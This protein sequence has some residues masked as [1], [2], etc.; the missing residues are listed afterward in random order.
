MTIS[1]TD[2]SAF[3]RFNRASVELLSSMRFAIALLTIISIASIIGTVIKQSEPYANYVNQ[4]GPFWAEIFNGLGLFAVYTAWW[5]LLILAFLVV[6]VSF[7]VLRNAPKMLADI[8]AWKEHVKEGGLRALHHH[9][10]YTSPLSHQ[11]AA[12][13]I[14]NRLVKDGYSVKTQLADD[15][16]KV[17]AKKGAASKWGY[18]FAHSAIVLICLG[19]LL[20]GD[21]FTRGQIWFGGKSILPSN[22]QGMLIS[23]IPS[24]HKLS[25]SNPSYRANI[26]VPEGGTSATALLSATSGSI[27]QELPFS[28]ELKKFHVEYYSTGMPKLF[29]SEVLIKDLDTGKESEAKIKVNEPLIHRGVAIYQSSFEDGGS[30]LKLRAYPMLGPSHSVKT[31]FMV[32]GEVG[33]ST[34]LKSSNGASYTLEF[35]GFRPTNVENIS[36]ASGQSDARGVATQSADAGLAKAF[37]NR[38]GSGAKTSK[39]TDLKNVGPSV[40][41]KLRDASGQA[42]EY[43]NYMQPLFLDGM[44]MF[45][46]GVRESAAQEFRYLRVPADANLSLNEWLTLRTILQDPRARQRAVERFAQ[47]LSQQKGFASS[48]QAIA[49]LKESAMR[50]IELFAGASDFAVTQA[51]EAGTMPGGFAALGGFIDQAVPEAE[52]EKAA[53]VILKVLNGVIWEL[54]QEARAQLNLAPAKPDQESQKFIQAATSALSDANFYPAPLVFQLDSFEEVK[55]SVFQVTRSPGKNMV[56]LGCLLLV[57]GIFAMFYLPERRIWVR[58]L[59]EGKNLFAMSTSRKTLDF[60]KEFTKYQEDLKNGN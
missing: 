12:D 23:E 8:R 53:E 21:L 14:A 44:P 52:R 49:Q 25:A 45:L 57:L 33:Q 5:F 1:S 56:Y 32:S 54:W 28:I 11:A 42:R 43:S 47:T 18:I 19:G 22:T 59:G 15:H 16:S 24:E 13:A 60:E 6:S 2:I 31:S 17:M 55:A 9:F 30:K 27:I 3:K 34:A 26:F 38:L 46:F 50:S 7:C 41:Y 40:Q 48:P 51:K 35:V 58:S 29:M 20:D 4:F 10:E 36:N 37:N 39:T